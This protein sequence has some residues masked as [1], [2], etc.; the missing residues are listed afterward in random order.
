MSFDR[1]L[2]LYFLPW[3]IAVL[4]SSTFSARGDVI[5]MEQ[6]ALKRPGVDNNY[7][8]SSWIGTTGSGADGVTIRCTVT[9][10]H[11]G[12]EDGII[13]YTWSINVHNQ[14]DSP[15]TLSLTL[16]LTDERK[17]VLHAS[18]IDRADIPARGTGGFFQSEPI[19]DSEWAKVFDHELSIVLD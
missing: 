2:S 7:T 18:T 16:I 9:L 8:E 17:E 19:R 4:L 13:K 10:K 5:E 15:L 1:I 11:T 14:A 12:L 3:L 6:L